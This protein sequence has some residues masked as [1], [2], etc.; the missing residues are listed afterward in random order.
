MTPP[1][2]VHAV[3]NHDDSTITVAVT[4]RWNR[5][6]LCLDACEAVSFGAGLRDALTAWLTSPDGWGTGSPP[7]ISGFSYQCYEPDEEVQIGYMADHAHPTCAGCGRPVRYTDE[8]WRAPEGYEHM[9]FIDA[10][11]PCDR[12]NGQ[13]SSTGVAGD[14]DVVNFPNLLDID[15]T[16]EG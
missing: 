6:A 13:W 1:D 15:F 2:P 12:L 14:G 9:D 4:F 5:Q 11:N 3:V 10:S 7:I 8:R 16:K